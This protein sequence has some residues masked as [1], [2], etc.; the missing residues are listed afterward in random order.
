MPSRLS[1]SATSTSRAP[2]APSGP[3]SGPQPARRPRP[4]DPR[5]T[6][7]GPICSAPSY[8]DTSDMTSLRRTLERLFKGPVGGMF[9]CLLIAGFLGGAAVAHP[10]DASHKATSEESSDDTSEVP[11]APEAPEQDQ[12][13]QD[14]AD[15]QQTHTPEDCTAARP[16]VR[17]Q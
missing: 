17:E 5:G 2:R 6:I 14:H 3:R 8:G 11:D 7:V 12:G 4:E 13:T 9:L 16:D 1:G 15:G 10:N